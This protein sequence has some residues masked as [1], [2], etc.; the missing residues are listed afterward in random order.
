[1]NFFSF[2]RKFFFLSFAL[3]ILTLTF[4]RNMIYAA[5][6][7]FHDEVYRHNIRSVRFHRSGS[8]MS[9]PVIALNSNDQLHLSFDDLESGVKAYRYTVIHCDA[10]WNPSDLWPT[11]YISGFADDLIESY[12]FSFN[13][14]IPFTHY[15]L[16]FPNERMRITLS[17]NY[18]L[19][20]FE[21]NDPAQVVLTRRFMVTDL[22]VDITE[23]SV[24]MPATGSERHQKQEVGFIIRSER[25]PLIDPSRN[26]HVRVVQN[27]RW[28]NA[29]M[30]QPMMVIGNMLDYRYNDGTTVFEAGNEF[31]TLDIRSLRTLSEQVSEIERT[32]NAFRVHLWPDQRRTFNPY[33]FLHDLNGRFQISAEN[34]R[35]PALESEYVLVHFTLEMEHAIPGANI[36]IFGMLSD[37]Q[38]REEHR[39]WFNRRTSAFEGKLLLKQ[40]V[41]DY[42]FVLLDKD[43]TSGN[44]GF[45]EGNHHQTGN[46]YTIYVYYRPPGARYD[47]LI[48]LQVINSRDFH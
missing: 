35:D 28:D 6:L 14:L 15:T 13:T 4:C 11:D 48:G 21:N 27:Q 7:R 29:L 8:D 32:P 47:H 38:A 40:G 25:I 30:L 22:K 3:A 12:Q 23:T 16:L 24:R 9:K 37:W 33:L 44:I 43:A 17:G 46:E 41:Y 26:L 31:H 20:V 1:M 39:M 34:T 5:E 36:Y 42:Q 2:R 19:K 18:I 10:L 45:I